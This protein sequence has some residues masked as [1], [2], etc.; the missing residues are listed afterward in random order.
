ME[1]RLIRAGI[2]HGDTNGVGY[3]VILKTFADERI[4]E[5][6]TPVIYGSLKIA[7]YHQRMMNLPPVNFEVISRTE[8]A[9][10]GKINLINCVDENIKVLPGQATQEAGV[11]AYRSLEAAMT[12][13]KRG[14]IDT[15]LTAPIN[16]YSI[17]SKAFHFPGH[18][19]Y[20]EAHFRENDRSG[21]S[22]MIL[23]QEQLRVAL[24]TGHIP[25][26]DVKAQ[27]TKERIVEKLNLFN[28]SLKQDFAIVRPRIAVL[29]LNPHAGDRGVL[30][31]E[32][33]T[34]IS[35]AIAEAEK[36]GLTVFGPY[37]ADGF[38]G[39]STYTRFDG[40]L[41]MYH[42]QGLIP[43][44]ALAMENGVNYTAGLPVVRT[45]PAHGTAYDI[46]GRNQASEESF[47][48]ALFVSMDIFRNRRIH[49]R[50]T[51]NPLQKQYVDRGGDN[52]KLDLTKEEPAE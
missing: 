25:L 49:R 48:R 11:A 2:T 1:G 40:I 24:V 12:D 13:V 5:L 46:A 45:S 31:S 39:S 42:D 9:V 7:L 43:F 29:S 27:V 47:R 36:C 21:G 17:R 35:P 51:A 34:V 16:K 18:T 37:A 28:V 26:G 14:A 10:E 22:L 50:I 33:E 19:E 20:L 8:E 3:E 15:L 38:F 52:V 4:V 41:A 23:M 6:C 44:K 32:E 30:G